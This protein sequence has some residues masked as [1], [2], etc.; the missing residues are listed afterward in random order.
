MSSPFRGLY[1]STR[2]SAS[3]HD[4]ADLDSGCGAYEN[5]YAGRTVAGLARAK[6]ALADAQRT[7][8]NSQRRRDR[9]SSAKL[10]DGR[11]QR[12]AAA[13]QRWKTH[14]APETD[15]LHSLIVRHQATIEQL[16]V[17]YDRQE[18]AARQLVQQGSNLR[19]AARRLAAGLEA[20]RNKVDG[21]AG[22]RPPDRSLAV[23][24]SY[25]YNS[26]HPN[27]IRRALPR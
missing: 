14:V 17:R 15:R 1:V 24:A 11:I 21:V 8:D 26:R 7:A 6:V 19:R 3:S 4:R 2:P 5:T 20:Y 18:A 12:E 9:R 13:H 25:E 27:T 22:H 16:T 23:F 10:V